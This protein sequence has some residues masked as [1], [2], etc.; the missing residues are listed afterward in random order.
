MRSERVG[1]KAGVSRLRVY[2]RNLKVKR[3]EANDEGIQSTS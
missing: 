1:T 2:S 3:L